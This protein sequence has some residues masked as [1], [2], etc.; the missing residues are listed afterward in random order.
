[1]EVASGEGVVNI[2]GGAF[3]FAFVRVNS[4][5]C[6]CSC[7]FDLAS[8]LSLGLGVRYHCCAYI[9]NIIMGHW[10]TFASGLAVVVVVSK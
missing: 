2:V 10:L 9:S 6:P 3:V 4:R 5:S 7:S 1:V 8:T